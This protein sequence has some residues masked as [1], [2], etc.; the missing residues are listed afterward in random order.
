M[1]FRGTLAKGLLYALILTLI[2]ITAFSAQKITPGSTCKVYKQKV[3][4]QNKVYTCIKS[5]TKLV[6]NKGVV[7]KKPTP[8][9]TP[10]PTPTPTPSPSVSPKSYS[11]Y[12]ETKLKAYSRILSA[13]NQ[14][15]ASNIQY[16]YQI[17]KGFPAETARVY[18]EQLLVASKLY[19]SFFNKKEI[20][21]VYMYSELE[22]SEIASN[23]VLN[24]FFKEDLEPWIR[25]YKVGLNT[26][27]PIGLV[28][29][30]GTLNGRSEG[31]TGILA[32]SKSD[33][34]TMY[35]GSNRL[36]IH[37]YFHVI[38][39]YHKQCNPCKW[40]DMDSYDNLMPR[41]FREG[42]A[43]TISLALTSSSPEKY[44]QLH[45]SFVDF[46]RNS[47]PIFSTLRDTDSVVDALKKLEKRSTYLQAGPAAY[48]L[49]SLLY[50]WVIAEYGFD[51]FRKI[52][53]NQIVAN[54]FEENI[55]MSLGITV[56]QMYRG[57]A[58]HILD[59]FK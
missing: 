14:N 8:K 16:V 10:T 52:I 31:H 39:D 43:E 23:N 49:G 33:L 53:E 42:S 48:Q 28:A 44:L 24:R 46:Q 41:T 4:N 55:K 34:N 32:S 58:Q 36:M 30:F 20:I 13:G 57:S 2:P 54:T 47:S 12:E 19:G 1:R 22:E 35:F 9:P 17:G 38:Q 5:G 3:T 18:Q 26:S 37:E 15:S 45:K 25:D 50:E 27:V 56:D 21:N 11:E 7:I 59:A 29:Q 40:T 6:W 51:S